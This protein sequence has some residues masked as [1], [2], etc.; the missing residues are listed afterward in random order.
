VSAIGVAHRTGRVV[1]Q[2]LRRPRR[3]PVAD[4]V[5]AAVSAWSSRHDE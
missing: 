3:D 5:P 2:V 1:A 4:H